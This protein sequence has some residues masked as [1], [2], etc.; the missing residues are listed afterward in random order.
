MCAHRQ[1]AVV[2]L[3][4]VANAIV[5]RVLRVIQ[6]DLA[7]QLVAFQMMTALKMRLAIQ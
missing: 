4:I 2:Q 1:L 5:H 6:R 7:S 3:L